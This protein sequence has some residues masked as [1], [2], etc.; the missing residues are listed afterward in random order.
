MGE[1]VDIE[2][3]ASIEVL[4]PLSAGG[5][6]SLFLARRV[7]HAGVSRL[8]VVKRLHAS[9]R[10]DPQCVAMLLDEA[11][12]GACIEH[13]LVREVLD[14]VIEDGVPS[15]VCAYVPGVSL[16]ELGARLDAPPP[17]PI[18]AAVAED[19]LSALHATHEARDASGSLL[20]VVHRDVSPQN[21]VVAVDG[22]TRL[23]DFGVAKASWNRQ[24]TLH[25]ETKGKPAYMAPEQAAG[26]R[27]DRRADLFGAALVL[28]ELAAGKVL[29]DPEARAEAL[30]GLGSEALAA[31]L[32]RALSPAARDRFDS[33]AAMAEALTRAARPA[34]RVEVASWLASVVG[35]ALAEREAMTRA[36]PARA[37]V[38]PIDDAAPA[39]TTRS[40]RSWSVDRKGA[41]GAMWPIAVAFLA[42]GVLVGR[43]STSERARAVAAEN[44]PVTAPIVTAAV[45]ARATPQPETSET[46]ATAS[47]APTPTLDKSA[48][49][50]ATTPMPQAPHP[51]TSTSTSTKAS[52]RPPPR[53]ADAGAPN[54]SPPWTTS[55]DGV[56]TY[57][58]ECL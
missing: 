39:P 16:A 37:G 54:C 23:I 53:A 4:G 20:G 9:M 48:A 43:C 32:R 7:S 24:T 29:S 28:L 11:R 58:P 47:A 38:R 44:V 26:Q 17:L 56:R 42:G 14:V 33:A 34:P 35:E 21:L 18:V 25:G 41:I 36:A 19:M 50:P 22:S 52:V 40:A 31:V 51:S 12:L 55:P 15:L 10:F 6:A 46:P 30:A 8:V 57:K 2:A 3:R 13:P 27:V 1:A 49:P 5:M 45:D